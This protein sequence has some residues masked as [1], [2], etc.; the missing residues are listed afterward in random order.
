M[1]GLISTSRGS[2]GCRFRQIV[3]LFGIALSACTSTHAD[4]DA[5]SERTHWFAT[6]QALVA[7]G[8]ADALMTAA[9]IYRTQ[10]TG[11]D[12]DS[13]LPLMDRA[14]ALEP[15]RPEIVWLSVQLCDDIRGCDS[16][17]RAERLQEIDPGNGAAVYGALK[18]A[19]DRGDV[20]AEDAA[21]EALASSD[22]FDIYWNRLVLQMTGALSAPDA[23]TGRALQA[24]YASADIAVG[25]LAAIALVDIGPVVSSCKGEQL[26]NPETL[27]RCRKI[28]D[29]MERGD[30]YIS[31]AMGFLI[32]TRVWPV[33]SDEGRA[34]D[35]RRLISR[36]RRDVA[37]ELRHEEGMTPEETE[38]FL[39]VLRTHQREQDAFATLLARHGRPLEPTSE[40][41]E[42]HP[43]AL[44]ASP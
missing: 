39:E 27:S 8:D 9:L 37:T 30:T 16:S 18:R 2:D 36:Y 14:I 21:L 28:A 11:S 42:K 6:A 43:P 40:W 33:D 29:V 35:E 1:D 24:P 12:R 10:L 17:L 44:S 4:R 31:E 19:R 13:A 32:G 26:A 15:T 5:A 34:L 7:R 38:E 20:A 22:R 41:R 3:L 25:S 23:S